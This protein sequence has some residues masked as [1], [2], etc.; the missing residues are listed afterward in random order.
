MTPESYQKSHQEFCAG[1]ARRLDYD[2]YLASLFAPAAARPAIWAVLAFAAELGRTREAVSEK[3]LGEVRLQWWRE[4]IAEIYG[5]APRAVPV[6]E[7]LAG[8]VARHGLSRHRLE[9]MVDARALDLSDEPPADLPELERYA[10]DTAG[11]VA[12]LTLES[13]GL[14]AGPELAAARHV[15]LAWALTGLVRSVAFHA[16]A[17][18]VFLP[19]D[20]MVRAGLTTG[21]VLGGR[22]PGRLTLA[23]S[24]V[25]G[26]A[27]THLDAA[28]GLAAEVP[29]AALP[30]L[31]PAVLAEA[32]LARVNGAS[33][34]L[35]ERQCR[36][37]L[38]A[39]RGRY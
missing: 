18:R 35:F 27:R 36:V 10:A 38:A 17:G 3:L 21:D 37:A 14:R 33:I 13:L 19:R 29:S 5:G 31:L 16:R 23:I 32:Y 25:T 26:A 28:R 11:E 39:F 2:R 6:V 15:G 22:Q 30:A 12:A 34:G 1:L 4:S 7:A 24:D 20:V 9:R 8:A